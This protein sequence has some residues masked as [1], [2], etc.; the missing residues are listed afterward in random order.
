MARR[1]ASARSGTRLPTL[2]V[3]EEDQAELLPSGQQT[4]C[5]NRVA[6]AITHMSQAGLLSRPKRGHY[7]IE[8]RGR[9][10][11]AVTG[12]AAGE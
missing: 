4:T 1:A 5:S 7:A 11:L 2:E 8:A 6:W 10:V 9:Q 12:I 3:S